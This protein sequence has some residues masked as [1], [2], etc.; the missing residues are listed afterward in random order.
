MEL[1]QNKPYTNPLTVV[2]T[3][4]NHDNATARGPEKTTKAVI[5][6]PTNCKVLSSFLCLSVTSLLDCPACNLPKLTFTWLWAVEEDVGI[7]CP[8]CDRT[9]WLGPGS[10]HWM[11]CAWPMWGKL[12]VDSCLNFLSDFLKVSLRTIGGKEFIIFF[13]KRRVLVAFQRTYCPKIVK[14]VQM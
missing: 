4:P 11:L 9:L 14:F 7:R 5:S 13:R 12:G 10:K 6:K 3:A 8:L 2:E 1:I